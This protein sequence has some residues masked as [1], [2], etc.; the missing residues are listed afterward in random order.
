M[1]PMFR[2]DRERPDAN[3]G[4]ENRPAVILCN[5]LRGVTVAAETVPRRRFAL[6]FSSGARV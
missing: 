5:A 4:A 1:P 2:G 3:G 6:A